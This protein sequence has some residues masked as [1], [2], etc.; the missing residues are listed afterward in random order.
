MDITLTVACR[1]PH[2]MDLMPAPPEVVACVTF[3]SHVHHLLLIVFSCQCYVYQPDN[4]LSCVLLCHL[5][6]PCRLTVFQHVRQ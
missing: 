5:N 1:T 4:A 2:A 3:V 6:M